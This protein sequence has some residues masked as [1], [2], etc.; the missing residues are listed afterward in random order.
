MIPSAA[1]ATWTAGQY[2]L[3][4]VLITTKLS[5]DD[6]DRQSAILAIMRRLGVGMLEVDFHQQ[7]RYDAGQHG[8]AALHGFVPG[9]QTCSSAVSALQDG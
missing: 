5:G 8:E 6:R 3:S 2:D 1:S 9:S 7:R 4:I